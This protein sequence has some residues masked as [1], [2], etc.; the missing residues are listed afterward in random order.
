LTQ[1]F[2]ILPHHI[3]DMTPREISEYITQLH[4]ARAEED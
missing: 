1:E 3:D 2:G 4:K